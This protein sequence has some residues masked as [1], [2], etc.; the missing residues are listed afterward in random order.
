MSASTRNH[1]GVR[2]RVALLPGDGV[3]PE[4]AAAATEVLGAVADAFGH[5]FEVTEGLLGGCAIEATGVPFP[6]AAATLVA[7]S[8]AVLLGAVG[9]PRWSDPSLRVRPEQGLLELRRVMEVYANLR[10]VRVVPAGAAVSPLR[11]ERVRD[12]DLLVVRELNGGL[13]YGEKHRERLDDGTGEVAWESCRYSSAEVER[14]VRVAASLAR[15]RRGRLTSVDKANVLETSRL[16]RDVTTRVM[17]DE[18]PDVALDHVYVDACAMYLIQD[19]R[20]FDVIVT[21]NLFGDILTD[22]AAVL[23]GAIGLLPSASLG[24][25]APQGNVRRG[26]YEPIHGSAPDIAGQ[27]RANPV[28]MILSVAMML[29]HSFVLEV[30]AVAIETAVD[31]VLDAGWRTADLLSGAQQARGT[32]EFGAEVA[33]RLGAG[34]QLAGGARPNAGVSRSPRTTPCSGTLDPHAPRSQS[35]EDP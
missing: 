20:R 3:G 7:S 35:S 14:V 23:A 11:P 30:E 28:G 1:D 26:L 2:A 8:E 18:F 10:P 16:W 34:A 17:R 32:A 6:P 12:V 31:A 21:E 25:A 4:V 15:A 9:G 24:D 5:R 22:E 13:Y 27:N 29:R 19:P 33:R